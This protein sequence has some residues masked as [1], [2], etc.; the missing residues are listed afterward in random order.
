MSPGIINDPV[1]LGVFLAGWSF[2]DASLLA[3]AT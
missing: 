1:T 3:Y 2:R